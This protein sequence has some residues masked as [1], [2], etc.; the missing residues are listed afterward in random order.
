[1][2]RAHIL[3]HRL[4]PLPFNNVQGA[5]FP[6]GA[7]VFEDDFE[8]WDGIFNERDA[9]G[10]PEAFMRSALW[11]NTTNAVASDKCGG[12]SGSKALRFSGKR[13]RW[14]VTQ[15]LDVRGGGYVSFRLKFGPEGAAASADCDTA[16]IGDVYL[17]YATPST[18][19]GGLNNTWVKLESFVPTF[20]P[21]DGRW[22][23]VSLNIPAQ[24]VSP[25]TRFKFDQPIFVDRRDHFAIDDLV[26]VFT[27]AHVL[28]CVRVAEGSFLR[29]C[30]GVDGSWPAMAAPTD[31]GA[32]LRRPC[33]VTLMRVH[34]CASSPPP[35]NLCSK[36]FTASK[37]A[38]TRASGTKT[39]RLSPDTGPGS[40]SAA[41][42]RRSAAWC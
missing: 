11:A 24:A 21:T 20:Y 3:S 10:R 17:Y 40:P 1:M 9:S 42:G 36:C 25:G 26:R 29:G 31:V 14:A 22:N 7:Y 34:L 15:P 16:Y 5:K 19:D 6:G 2:A 4:P 23:W 8:H 39:R 33:L 38:G 37:R 12:F 13:Q 35:P 30:V 18:V 28:L 27:W 32:L 41:W